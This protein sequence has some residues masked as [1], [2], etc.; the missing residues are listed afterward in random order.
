MKKI[1]S[2]EEWLK[3]EYFD[4]ESGDW[5]RYDYNEVMKEYA[6]YYH[7]QFTISEINMKDELQRYEIF[8]SVNGFNDADLTYSEIIEEYL[9]PPQ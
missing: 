1:K 4:A 7:H 9:T 6:E 2:P 3:D 5:Q 8:K